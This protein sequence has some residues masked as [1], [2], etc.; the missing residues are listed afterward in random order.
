MVKIY[1]LVVNGVVFSVSSVEGVVC[2]DAVR[3]ARMNPGA[4]VIVDVVDVTDCLFTLL[5]DY[6]LEVQS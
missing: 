1:R 6:S 2:N 3:V 4:T 5:H